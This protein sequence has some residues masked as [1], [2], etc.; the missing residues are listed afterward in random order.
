VWTEFNWIEVGSTKY[1]IELRSSLKAENLLRVMQQFLCLPTR[2]MLPRGSRLSRIR[3]RIY[4]YL[5][6]FIYVYNIRFESLKLV[7]IIF[8]FG[9]VF[10]GYRP[11][12]CYTR[13][14]LYGICPLFYWVV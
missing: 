9:T 2:C 8:K 7:R 10:E 4:I 3:K 13:D 11:T 14:Y 1:G 6:I 12:R 5:F